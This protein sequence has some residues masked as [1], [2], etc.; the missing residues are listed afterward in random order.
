MR[1]IALVLAAFVIS[2]PAAA[3]SW[4]EYNYPEDSFSVMFPAAP[5]IERTPHEVADGR[6]VPAR[7]YSVREN[8]SELEMTVADLAN[9]GLDEKT[10]IAYAVEKLSAGGVVK[11]DIPHR[12]YQV[13]GRQLSITGADGNLSTIAL[14][15]IGGRLYQIEAKLLPGGNDFDLIR[16]HQSLVF[17]RG[18]SN[19]SE[20]DVRA[21]R[22]ACR[23]L[24]ANPAGFD[25][26][27]CVRRQ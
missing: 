13:Y 25:D 9:T 6:M 5:K 20:E 8:N 23:G 7:V 21:F 14:F 3:Q 22:E 24:N 4:Q 10:V 2:G 27:R 17:E 16:F 11:I 19:R 12:I 1:L 26:P 18:I 15:D